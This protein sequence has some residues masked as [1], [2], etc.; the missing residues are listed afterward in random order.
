[1]NNSLFTPLK[2]DNGTPSGVPLEIQE[3][4]LPINE[5]NGT[6]PVVGCPISNLH[7]CK[8]QR[9]LFF[10]T[11]P[12]GE[13]KRYR[14]NFIGFFG[15]GKDMQIITTAVDSEYSNST[16]MCTPY[17]WITKTLSLDDILKET[18]LPRDVLLIIDNYL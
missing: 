8:G 11:T 18:V 9:Y 5:L 7:Q 12:W 15:N 17:S 1:M 16:I 4:Q 13:L 2:I 10:E 3:Q 14:A 6:P